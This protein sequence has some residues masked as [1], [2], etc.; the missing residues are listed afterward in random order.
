M[1]TPKPPFLSDFEDCLTGDFDYIII[2]SSFCAF[3]FVEQMLRKNPAAKILIVEKGCYRS[4]IPR[5]SP[6]E[7]G[8]EEKRTEEV[9]WIFLTEDKDGIIENVRGINCFVGGRSCFWKAWCPKPKREEMDGWPK[10][11][12]EKVLEYFPCAEELLSVR[13]VNEIGSGEG[14][15]FNR[16]QDVIFEQLK[17]LEGEMKLITKHASLALTEKSSW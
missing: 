5:Y 1:A 3:G 12:V 11:V 13:P 4:D 14:K 10:V 17:T 16:L 9:P 15:P 2:G 8:K 6:T 7:L